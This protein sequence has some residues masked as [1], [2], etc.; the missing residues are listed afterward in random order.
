MNINYKRSDL[1]YSL[2]IYDHFF[3]LDNIEYIILSKSAT[4]EFFPNCFWN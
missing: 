2:K 4:K 3:L 1:G